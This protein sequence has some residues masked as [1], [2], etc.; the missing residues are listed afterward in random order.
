M[1]VAFALRTLNEKLATRSQRERHYLT[2]LESRF[3]ISLS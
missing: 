1:V 3:E 2:M